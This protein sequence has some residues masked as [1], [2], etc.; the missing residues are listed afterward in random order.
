MTTRFPASRAARSTATREP[1]A[2]SCCRATTARSSFA[3]SRSRRRAERLQL[4]LL[5]LTSN[6]PALRS[7]LNRNYVSRSTRHPRPLRK[8]DDMAKIATKDGV[9]IFYKD[10]GPRNAQPLVFHHGWP[11]SADDWD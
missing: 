6:G 9:E 10:W 5:A 1:R 11:L 4:P 2:R 8:E 3:T 7:R